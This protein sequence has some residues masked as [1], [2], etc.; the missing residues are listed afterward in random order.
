MMKMMM[1]RRTRIISIK[2]F[3]VRFQ[4]RYHVAADWTG[5]DRTESSRVD[6]W[7]GIWFWERRWL[8][9]GNRREKGGEE[10]E[11]RKKNGR[12]SC[13]GLEWR[14]LIVKSGNIVSRHFSVT[15]K[16]DFS[17][18]NFFA[19]F[20]TVLFS[21]FSLQIVSHS[22]VEKMRSFESIKISWIGIFEQFRGQCKK[23]KLKIKKW[24]VGECHNC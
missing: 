3:D 15:H 5:Q 22:I 19:D 2:W 24:F 23:G 1:M 18:I 6:D 7:K 14:F 8:V 12:K 17:G 4:D 16:S 13:P 21:S 11:R 9:K 10:R 20:S